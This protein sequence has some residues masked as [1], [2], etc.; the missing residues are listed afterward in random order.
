MSLPNTVE[1]LLIADYVNSSLS[2][3]L[4]SKVL[5]INGVPSGSDLSS[6]EGSYTQASQSGSAR[7]NV[8][9]RSSNSSYRASFRVA[10]RSRGPDGLVSGQEVRS[11]HKCTHRNGAGESALV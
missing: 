10:S 2:N 9:R 4:V 11:C 3:V 1:H 6:G 7:L 8:A 5:A